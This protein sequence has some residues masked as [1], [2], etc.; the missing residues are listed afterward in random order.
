M[1][2]LNKITENTDR[3]KTGTI[4]EIEFETLDFAKNLA[5]SA[6]NIYALIAKAKSLEIENCFLFQRVADLEEEISDLK[7]ASI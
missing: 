5:E 4:P 3:S 6:K 7:A 1:A 2:N